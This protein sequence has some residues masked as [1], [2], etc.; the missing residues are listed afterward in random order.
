MKEFQAV[1]LLIG[2]CISEVRGRRADG[3]SWGSLEAAAP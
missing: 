3:A 1:D 2:K